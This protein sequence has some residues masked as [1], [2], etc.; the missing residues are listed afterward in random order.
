MNRRHFLQAG[1]AAAALPVLDAQPSNEWGGPVLDIHLHLRREPDSCFDH[2]EGSGVTKAILLTQAVDADK[3]KAEID[4]RPG[5]FVWSAAGNPMQPEA[6]ENI[7]KGVQSGARGIGE[8][9]NHLAADSPEMQRLYDLAAELNV[10]IL[11]HFQEV[12]HFDGEGVFATGF[13]KFDRMLKAHPKTTFIGHADF[14]WANISDDYSPGVAYPSGP[15]KRGGLTDKWLSDFANF[16]VDMSANSGYNG[17]SRDA[18]FTRGFLV[19]HQ[20]KLMF[21]CDCSC[22]D[23]RGTNSGAILPQLK[24]KCVARETL[25]VA[26]QLSSPEVFR[27]IT[28]ENGTK[29][30]KIPT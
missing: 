6:Y 5:R 22:K 30:F 7:R 21:G 12:A 28:W 4:K 10:P 18:E 26:K 25:T 14:V 29:L 11:I 3:A 15:V 16:Y 20:N 8:I 17:L 13:T 27:K 19:R 24:G 9:K 23:G 1:L 2:I